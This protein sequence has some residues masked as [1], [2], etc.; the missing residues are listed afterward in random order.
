MK[1][2]F[3]VFILSGLFAAMIFAQKNNQKIWSVESKVYKNLCTLYLSQGYA[4]PSSVGPWSSDELIKM[5]D[6][7]PDVPES[8]E[9][10]ALFQLYNETVELLS[11]SAEEFFE[12][13]FDFN[14]QPEMYIH[15]NPE[16][17]NAT[18]D[19]AYSFGQ[20][21]HL[22]EVAA[23]LWM[24]RHFYSYSRMYLGQNSGQVQTDGTNMLYKPVFNT[25]IPF[26]PVAGAANIDLNFPDRAICSAG[27]ENWS[28]SLGRDVMRWGFGET[29]NLFLGGNM[30]YDNALRFSTYFDSFKYTFV[31]N[32]YPHPQTSENEGSISQNL[33]VDGIKMFMT[34]RIDFRF[35]GDKMSLG[36]AEGM[37][38]QSASSTLDLR[39]FNP[40]GFFHNY[41]IRGNSNSILG[42]D[43]NYTIFRNLSVFASVVLDDMP[44]G[45]PDAKSKKPWRPSKMGYQLGAKYILPV[46]SGILRL[47]AEA[48]YTD[49]YLYIRERYIEDQKQQGLS[50]YGDLR[51]FMMYPEIVYFTECIGY[52][53]GGNCITANLNAVYESCGK[54]SAGAELFYMA[55]GF[56]YK[57]ISSVA[58]DS[59]WIVGKAPLA[60]FAKDIRTD[61]EGN[62]KN[63]D[64][65]G[66]ISHYLRL[67]VN[68]T[69]NFTD[70]I[71]V[72]GRMD[73][74]IIWNKTSQ[75]KSAV[76]DL[77]LCAGAKFSL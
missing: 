74:L 29:G 66:N 51:C 19:W 13:Q 54:W 58:G 32:F 24:A 23:E 75:N 6:K 3:L 36:V 5:L 67:S 21:K 18:E 31:A 20:R 55:H 14:F 11:D 4:L 16:N 1:K 73:N 10:E 17:F 15:T 77:Q 27:G 46:E 40:A 68:G 47:S 8:Y 53:Y 64:F 48:V 45:E 12:Y 56:S 30:L 72:Y 34:H 70:S 26:V 57:D 44:F 43:Y 7:L 76:Y 22:A 65:E 71:A 63:P 69:Y 50:L 62:P 2:I 38:Y 61:F 9:K 52:K 33:S 49:P 41:F 60:P 25:N 42:V 59:D 35:F 39:V 28:L 37:M